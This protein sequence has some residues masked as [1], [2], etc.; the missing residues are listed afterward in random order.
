MNSTPAHATAQAG[1]ATATAVGM[2]RAG[3]P[4]DGITATTG[5]TEHEIAAAVTLA[6]QP[7]THPG[8]GAPIEDLLAWAEKHDAKSVRATA[9]RARDALTALRTR[10]DA[11]QAVTAAESKIRALEKQLAA[12]RAELRIARTGTIPVPGAGPWPADPTSAQIRAWAAHT[13]LP[14]NPHGR[15]P[16][17]VRDAYQA[18]RRS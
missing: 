1:A 17:A 11:D 10:R 12:A 13:G 16:D 2:F 18:A 14:C 4:V 9:R 6:D 8:N 5:L 3:T 7:P 15:V